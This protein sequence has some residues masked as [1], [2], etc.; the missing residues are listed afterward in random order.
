[1]EVSTMRISCLFKDLVMFYESTEKEPHVP[2]SIPKATPQSE[3]QSSRLILHKLSNLSLRHDIRVVQPLQLPLLPAQERDALAH[4][5]TLLTRMPLDIHHGR[6]NLL[7]TDALL[8]AAFAVTGGWYEIAAIL[9]ATQ[10]TDVPTQN[11]SIG[12]ALLA[13]NTLL[14]QYLVE[15]QTS[16]V[17]EFLA[18]LSL[19][20]DATNGLSVGLAAL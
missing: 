4:P 15:V 9:A 19:V 13:G 3:P 14:G 18:F 16:L 12:A 6:T 8:H 11:Q 7:L 20:R 17:V 1:M 10:V 2:N 5:S